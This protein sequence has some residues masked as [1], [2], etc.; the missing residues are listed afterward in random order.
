MSATDTPVEIDEEHHEEVRQ[1]FSEDEANEKKKKRLRIILV[2]FVVVVVLLAIIIG[3]TVGGKGSDTTEDQIIT[4]DDNFPSASPTSAPTSG[5]LFLEDEVDDSASP[6]FKSLFCLFN[7]TNLRVEIALHE[8]SSGSDWEAE[9]NFLESKSDYDGIMM[10]ST[11]FDVLRSTTRQE[12]RDSVIYTVTQESIL[13]SGVYESQNDT[14]RGLNIPVDIFSSLETAGVYLSSDASQD[15]I[16]ND[17]FA[18]FELLVPT[19]SPTPEP[20]PS[21]T[22]SPSAKPT[23]LPTLSPSSLPT[24]VP[25]TLAPTV[26]GETLAPS[27][28]PSTVPS[29]EP[30]KIPS[31]GPSS[32]PTQAPSVMPSQS[33]QPS[34]S[35]IQDTL[36]PSSLPSTSPSLFPTK[37]PT[38]QPTLSPSKSPTLQPTLSPSKSPTLKPTMT[39]PPTNNPTKA[40]T[41]APTTSAPT[42]EGQL[43]MIAEDACGDVI[44]SGTATATDW[45]KMTCTASKE[46]LVCT[47]TA[48]NPFVILYSNL[49]L[50]GGNRLIQILEGFILYYEV[51]GQSQGDAIQGVV[52]EKT[53]TEVTFQIQVSSDQIIVGQ[54]V[55]LER[56]ALSNADTVLDRLPDAGSSASFGACV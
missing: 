51:I 50:N 27:K 21:P 2:G 39:N 14:F 36:E 38:L 34:L 13:Y 1:S 35:P 17:G 55:W 54:D 44:G 42:T 48:C 20:S 22:A 40:P 56:V 45:E 29:L 6:D 10:N 37:S 52:L 11:G 8:G 19:N 25:T 32:L 5:K 15:R 49:Y 12:T 23:G 30:S 16:P 18:K 41:K 31:N 47:L 24:R 7:S 4:T 46:S 33:K 43:C 28:A 26:V 3:A 53:E 9:L